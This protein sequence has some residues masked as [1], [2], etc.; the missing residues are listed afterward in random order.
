MKYPIRNNIID[1]ITA[2]EI[3]TYWVKEIIRQDKIR[4]KKGLPLTYE[5]KN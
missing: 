1:S 3:T 2:K 4:K 5:K